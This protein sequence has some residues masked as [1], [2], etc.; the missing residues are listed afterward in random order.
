MVSAFFILC[1]WSTYT[2]VVV[3]QL[4][5][6]IP[7]HFKSAYLH[8][9]A[10]HLNPFKT[11]AFCWQGL[12]AEVKPDT[13]QNVSRIAIFISRDTEYTEK[14]QRDEIKKL[15]SFKPSVCICTAYQTICIIFLDQQ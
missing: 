11:D 15:E 5:R 14:K 12:V 13:A 3:T 7:V 10:E 1:N 2:G 9:H 4:D 8:Q 6:N